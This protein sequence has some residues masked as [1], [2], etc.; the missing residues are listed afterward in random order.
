MT[1]PHEPTPSGEDLP[2]PE[3]EPR[4]RWKV[5]FIWLVPLVALLVGVTMIV[6]TWVLAGPQIVISFDNARGIQAGK[7]QVKYKN[8]EIGKVSDLGLSDDR[9]EV[10][11]T[12][13]LD[14]D[15]AAFASDDSRFWVVRPRVGTGGVSGL[16]TLLSGAYI[17]ADTGSSKATQ[18]HFKGL[19]K[20]PPVTHNE[21][22]STFFLSSDD[23][24]SLDIGSPVYYRR[25]KVGR[26][27]GYELDDDG[28]GVTIQIFVESPE[29]QF[30]EKATRF[31]NASGVNLSVDAGGL[32]VNTESLASVVT[33]GVAFKKPEYSGATEPAKPG[34]SFSLFDDHDTAMQPPNG[35][36][37]RLRMEFRQ[38]VRGLSEGAPVDF[39]GVKLGKVT[40]VS[41]DYDSEAKRFPAEVT[42][43]V[44]PQRIGKAHARFVK[45]SGND[46]PGALL[47][48]LVKYGLRAQLRTGN[49]LTGKLYVAMDF[50]PDADDV[51]FDRK[52]RP[53][54]LPTKSGSFDKL[55][56]Q[57]ADIV[58]KLHDVPFADIGKHLDASLVDLD[59]TLK[60]FHGDLEPEVVSALQQTQKT[61]NDVS[62]VLS[63]DSPMRQDLGSTLQELQRT[64]RSL[65]VLSNYLSRHPESLLRGR[66][67]DKQTPVQDAT[68]APAAS[69]SSAS[70]RKKEP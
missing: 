34:M 61:M 14:Y 35:K 62:N 3:R 32:E 23:L 29:D 21:K 4:K 48:R 17:G 64:A 42:A 54:Q 51:D 7:T 20:A 70:G 55:Q 53:L 69:Q 66:S 16:G 46:K 65:R 47:G 44:Y 68:K 31:W 63:M 37:L 40:D 67:A 57:A 2:E 1:E 56:Q 26:V 33:G 19:N 59:K 36:P 49:L 43:V 58:D 8:V 5:S 10:Q 39:L 24:G 9:G 15:T 18:T 30:V 52:K 13:D 50:F 28:Q 38:S 45:H 11:V 41:L 12:V 6:R 60:Q 25:I 22:G 27:V